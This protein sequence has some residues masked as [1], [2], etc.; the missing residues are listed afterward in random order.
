MKEATK[1]SGHCLCGAVRFEVSGPGTSLSLCH[2]A[3]CR[4]SVG[5]TPVAWATFSRATLALLGAEPTWYQSSPEARRGFCATCGCSLF[6]ESSACPDDLDVTT[7]CLD[8][9]DAFAPTAHTW[10]PSKVAWARTDDG[11]PRHAR[12][13]SSPPIE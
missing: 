13:S 4:L 10:V 12:A 7:A 11:L 5:A 8:Q 2:C 3:M 1:T 6:F 9:V